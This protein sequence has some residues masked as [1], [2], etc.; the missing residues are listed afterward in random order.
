MRYESTSLNRIVAV[1]TGC[2]LSALFLCIHSRSLCE[3]QA[4]RYESTSF[5]R[6]VARVTGCDYLT[7]PYVYTLG[8]SG[9]FKAMRKSEQVSIES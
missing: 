6:I 8:H 9:N 7:Y 4:M 1:V 2:D 5:N 3:F